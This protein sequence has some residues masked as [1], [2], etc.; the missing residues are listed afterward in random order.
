MN[1]RCQCQAANIDDVCT[2]QEQL[3]Q[4]KKDKL[5]QLLLKH[6]TLFDGT[7]GEESNYS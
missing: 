1:P 7:L 6:K 3:D 2:H 5:K 4:V